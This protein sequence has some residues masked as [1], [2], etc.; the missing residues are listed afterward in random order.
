MSGKET[1]VLLIHGANQADKSEALNKQTWE[2][3]LKVESHSLKVKGLLS[4]EHND[5][6]A[7][8]HERNHQGLT[9]PVYRGWVAPWYGDIWQSIES[10]K[11]DGTNPFQARLNK[12]SDEDEND[13]GSLLEKIEQKGMQKHFDELVPF[14]EL[15]VRSDND[16]TLYES[17]CGSVLDQLIEA[18][19]S[20]MNYVLVAHSM[21]CAVSYNVMSHI[22]CASEGE[23]YCR[24]EGALSDAYRGK[25]SAFA[26]SQSKCLGL[27]TF[28]NYIGY[29]WC[30]GLNNRLLYGELKKQY[31]YP[32]AVG[33]WFNFWTISGGDPY[34]IDDMLGDDIVDDTDGR[35]DDVLVWRPPFVNIGHGRD[36]W[37]RRNQFAKKLYDRMAKHLYL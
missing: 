19:G 20:R 21:G 13:R 16:Q 5:E 37:F 36:N 31:V 25:V 24:I 2:N 14:Y 3:A 4:G 34:I 8:Y 1:M 26:D 10:Q 30:Q 29:N 6:I 18:T 28:G 12:S 27:M 32:S 15:A 35:Y 11:R 9:Y 33:R 17:I 7:R 22:S 23:D